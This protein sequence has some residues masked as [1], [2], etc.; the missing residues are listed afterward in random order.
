MKYTDKNRGKEMLNIIEIKDFHAPELD[1]YARRTEAQ[2]LNKE[3]P[4]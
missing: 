4:E 2:L 1:V 3:H